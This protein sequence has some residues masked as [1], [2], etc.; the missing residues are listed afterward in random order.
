MPSQLPVQVSVCR[1]SL[2]SHQGQGF[3]TAWTKLRVEMGVINGHSSWWLIPAMDFPNSPSVT[4]TCVSMAPWH[5]T[6]HT[7]NLTSLGRDRAQTRRCWVWWDNSTAKASYHQVSALFKPSCS[8]PVGTPSWGSQESCSLLRKSP[9]CCSGQ[10][11]LSWGR[12]TA[13][14]RIWRSP[15]PVNGTEQRL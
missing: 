14:Q 4:P 1:C 5:S 15:D 3:P 6:G 11:V 9:G 13:P 8:I 7:G 12:R 2:C 10:P